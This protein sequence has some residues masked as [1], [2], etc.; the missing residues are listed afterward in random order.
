MNKPM[1]IP[2]QVVSLELAKQLKEAGYPQ[3]GLFHWAHYPGGDMLY[4]TRDFSE[5]EPELVCVAP[6]VAELGEQLLKSNKLN[7][8]STAPLSVHD[9]SVSCNFCMLFDDYRIEGKTEA[10]ARAKMWL[11]LKEEDLL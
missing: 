4:C 6:T 1:T 11:L 5:T 9:G 10:E 8:F 7:H 2:D 3:E